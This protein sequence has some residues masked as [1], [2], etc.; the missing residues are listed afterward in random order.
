MV[1]RG[2]QEVRSSQRQPIERRL[3]FCANNAVADATGR[4]MEDGDHRNAVTLGR[5]RRSCERSGDRVE[6]DGARA[7]LLRTA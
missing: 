7:K 4:L 2:D 1:A 5:E 3:G 6:Q